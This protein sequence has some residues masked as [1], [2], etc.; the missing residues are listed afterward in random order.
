MSSPAQTIRSS[1]ASI[2]AP[3]VSVN[4][5]AS[6]ETWIS[7]PIYAVSMAPIELCAFR[8]REPRTGRWV[9]ARY[10][11]RLAEIKARYR[12]WEVDGPA[13]LRTDAPVQMFQPHL[14]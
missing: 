6:M 3:A 10:R 1:S 12:E 2:I 14:P 11:A 9:R 7:C 8:F 4:L 5:P 13:E